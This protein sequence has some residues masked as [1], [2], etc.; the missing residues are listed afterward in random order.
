[1]EKMKN[2]SL[3][4]KKKWDLIIILSMC[5]TWTV[6]IHAKSI[7]NE[8]G[9]GSERVRKKMK[10]CTKST[11]EWWLIDDLIIIIIPKCLTSSDEFVGLARV[12]I[13]FSWSRFMTLY[14]YLDK[15]SYWWMI[16]LQNNWHAQD[17]SIMNFI[18]E[19]SVYWWLKKKGSGEDNK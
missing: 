12:P 18:V 3:N 13:F 10:V 5:G 2:M 4:T 6:C 19:W 15:M 7:D 17:W 9:V 8:K 14:L 16:C 1:M 11:T